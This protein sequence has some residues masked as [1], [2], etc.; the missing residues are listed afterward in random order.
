M[1]VELGASG[2]IFAAYLDR[3]YPR[4]RWL[5]IDS[6]ALQAFLAAAPT[7]KRLNG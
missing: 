5:P 2:Q 6:H 3:Q 4:Q 7:V 1:Y